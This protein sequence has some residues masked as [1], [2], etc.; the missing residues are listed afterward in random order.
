MEALQDVVNAN[1]FTSNPSMAQAL[2]Q[3]YD[4]GLSIP[5]VGSLVNTTA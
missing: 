1:A 3:S 4:P 2:L 5:Q